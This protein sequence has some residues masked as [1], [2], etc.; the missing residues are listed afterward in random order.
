MILTGTIKVLAR[1]GTWALY[2]CVF[3]TLPKFYNFPIR[4]SNRGIQ[5]TPIL[6]DF[7]FNETNFTFKI[8]IKNNIVK[9][10]PPKKNIQGTRGTCIRSQL[11][12]HLCMLYQRID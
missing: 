2:M 8:C 10:P 9:P 6:A 7:G 1:S 5:E 12:D 4:K 3:K 11:I